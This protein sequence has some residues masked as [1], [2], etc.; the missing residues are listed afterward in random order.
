MTLLTRAAYDKL[1]MRAL[2]TLKVRERKTGKK[3]GEPYWTRDHMRLV[4]IGGVPHTDQLVFKEAWG[5]HSARRLLGK[6]TA[7]RRAGYGR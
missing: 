7:A 5:E 6:Y 2:N 4:E 1:Y 3:I